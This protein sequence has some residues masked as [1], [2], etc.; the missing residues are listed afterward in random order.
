M[1]V[2]QIPPFFLVRTCLRIGR[3]LFPTT[4]STRRPQS[5][6]VHISNEL[7]GD[8]DPVYFPHFALYS[9]TASCAFRAIQYQQ[10]LLC[11]NSTSQHYSNESDF[12][13]PSSLLPFCQFYCVYSFYWFYWG[14]RP[15]SPYSPYSF[16]EYII[17][18]LINC[19]FRH[20]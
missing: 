12:F 4:L 17:S 20:Y 6:F 3:Y 8:L 13:A 10:A 1:H 7:S 2:H 18:N 9:F 11:R 14:Y 19:Y 16:C 15:C 5:S